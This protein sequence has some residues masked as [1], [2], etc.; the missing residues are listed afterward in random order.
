MAFQIINELNIHCSN[1]PHC[2]WVGTLDTADTHIP[3]CSSSA[4]GS[5]TQE[6]PQWYA[7]YRK[8]RGDPE[9]LKQQQQLPAAQKDPVPE[10][11]AVL[12]EAPLVREKRAE[13]EVELVQ[14]QIV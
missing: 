3:K 13:I 12:Q 8:S 10:I 7:T 14:V 11:A 2:E 4:A 5:A 9:P 6:P 1:H